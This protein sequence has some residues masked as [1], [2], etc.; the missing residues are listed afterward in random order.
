RSR[1]QERSRRQGGMAAVGLAVGSAHALLEEY[2]GDLEIA[3]V[4][5]PD[6]VTV[7]GSRDALERLVDRLKREREDVLAQILRVDYAFHSRQMDGF[8]GELRASLDSLTP[9]APK[10]PMYSTVTGEA[11]APGELD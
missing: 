6:L 8:T 3:A 11:V 5:A 4:N 9:V 10:I 2:E 7:A 1:L